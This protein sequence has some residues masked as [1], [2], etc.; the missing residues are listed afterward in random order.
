MTSEER[1]RRFAEATRSLRR[2]L[3]ELKFARETENLDYALARAERCV[4]ECLGEPAATP[5]PKPWP[6]DCTEC[7][8][9]RPCAKAA[10]P[11][12]AQGIG[13]DADDL[14]LLATRVDVAAQTTNG[15]I[16][17]AIIAERTRERDTARA[18]QAELAKQRRELFDLAEERKATLERVL[19]VLRQHRDDGFGPEHGTGPV[20]AQAVR[21]AEAAAA[22]PPEKK[23]KAG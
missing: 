1:I 23:E 6:C 12:A 3:Y 8:F 22:A 15:M 18:E 21:A 2:V 10:R 17:A 7:E 4:N 14:Y 13:A 16:V 19:T 20:W 5:T 11:T 9:G